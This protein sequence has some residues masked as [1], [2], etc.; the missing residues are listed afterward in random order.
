MSHHHEN[1]NADVGDEGFLPLVQGNQAEARILRK[2]L[3]QLADGGA[4]TVL[5]EMSQ[6]IL[7]GRISVRE[8]I[9]VPAYAEALGER[10]RTFREDWERTSPEERAA[11]EESARAFLE[12]QRVEIE[13]EG[14]GPQSGRA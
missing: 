4:G 9:C 7:A 1:V 6:E 2:H 14:R 3:Q 12:A 5:R 8:A 11:H 10:T 13:E